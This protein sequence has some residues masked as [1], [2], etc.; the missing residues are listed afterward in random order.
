MTVEAAASEITDVCTQLVERR[1][2][3]RAGR[4]RG[5]GAAPVRPP[6]GGP[7]SP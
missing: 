4:D 1:W 2:G 7:R 6:A 5:A 3:S